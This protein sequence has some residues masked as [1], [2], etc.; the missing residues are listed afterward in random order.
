MKNLA[1]LLIIIFSFLPLHYGAAVS[2]KS[3]STENGVPVHFVNAPEI[4][5]VDIHLAFTA[6]SIRDG[7]KHGLS[8]MVSELILQGAA[9]LN[10]DSFNEALGLT[11]G[12]LTA[13]SS[14]DMGYIKARSLTD[15]T[16]LSDVLMLLKLAL[17]APRFDES[18]VDRIKARTL[19]GLEYKKQSP[20]AAADENL[21]AKLF[22]SHPYGY[23]KSGSAE[24]VGSITRENIVTFFE[25]FYVSANLNIS[26]VGALNEGQAKKFAEEI[27]KAL[28][29][30]SRAEKILLQPFTELGSSSVAKNFPSIQSH[31]RV[32][33]R[34]VERGHPDY[35][36]L[37]VANHALGGNSLV[38]ILFRAI[39]EEKGLAYSAYS[40]FSPKSEGGTLVAALQTDRQ[41]QEEA[42]G[43]LNRSLE[44]LRQN[45]FSQKDIDSA[46]NNLI[47]GF[48]LRIDTNAEI[49]NYLAMLGFY[50]LPNNYLDTFPKK[51]EAIT[52]QEA[53]KT[54]N[55]YFSSEKL[56]TV[57]VGPEQVSEE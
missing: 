54:F 25:R 49:L 42:L 10:V 6:G 46:K 21:Y 35:F 44:S 29:V 28:S 2:V 15:S 41:N 48:P 9:D 18:D 7:N 8:N 5:M 20:A 30:G 13:G 56:V 50:K 55:R 40:Y 32:G 14:L 47:S 27:S 43:A 31:I 12:I 17:S 36:S 34:S 16:K 3:W 26:I 45:G 53:S 52:R 24:T 51:V 19:V 4:N 38:S 33:A 22:A 39:R 11:G 57:I 1:S 23:P 37:L